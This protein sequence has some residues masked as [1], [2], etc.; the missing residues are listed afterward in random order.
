MLDLLNR[1]A[2]GF[3]TIPVILACKERGFFNLL[4]ERGPLTAAQMVDVLGANSGHFQAALRLMQSL[5]WLVYDTETGGYGLTAKA[6]LHTQIPEDMLDLY[7]L[8][9]EDYLMGASDQRLLSP[10]LERSRRRWDLGHP[11]LADFLDGVLVVPLLLSLKKNNLLGDGSQIPLFSGVTPLAGEELI[12][13]FVDGGWAERQEGHPVLTDMGRFVVDRSLILGTTASYRPMLMRMPDLLFGDCRAVFDRDEAGNEGHLDRSLNVLAS[14]FQHGKYFAD[15]DAII[16]SIFNQPLADQPHYIVDM[17]CGDGTFLA[18]VYHTIRT[19]SDRGRMLD[20]HPLR[21]I[22]VDYNQQA[23]GATAKTLAD[24]PHLVLPGDIGDP[25]QLMLNLQAHG[26]NFEDVLHI[27]SFLDHNRPFSP[28]QDNEAAEHR[29]GTP[30]AGVFVDTTGHAIPPQVMVQSLVEHLE[31]WSRAVSRHGIIILEVHCLNP[32]AVAKNRDVSES[33]HFDAY[34]AFSGQH[35]VEADL[36]LMSAAEVGLFPQAEF[37]RHY[38]KTLP[39]TRITLTYFEKKPYRM[40]L[41]QAA[42]LPHLLH[43]E[44]VCRPEAQRLSVTALQERLDRDPNGQCVL[45]VEGTIVGVIYSRRRFAND[46]GSPPNSQVSV[47]QLLNMNLLPTVPDDYGEQL[48][49]FMQLYCSVQSNIERVMGVD[50]CETYLHARN[51]AAVSI[52]RPIQHYVQEFVAGYPLSAGEDPLHPET[53]LETFGM[54]WLLTLLQDRG[55]M[56]RAGEIYARNDLKIR[57]RIVPQYYRLFDALLAMFERRGLLLLRDT[58]VETR[59]G[60]EAFTLADVTA[61]AQTFRQSFVS[62]YP[63]SVAFLNLME[64]CLTHYDRVLT[65]ETAAND[66]I[67]PEGSMDLFAGIFTG[68]PISDYFNQLLAEVVFQAIQQQKA[69]FNW[70]KIRILEIGAGTGGA[71]EFVLQKIAALSDSL[72]FTYSDISATFTRYGQSR[73]AERFPWVSY[74]TLNIEAKLEEQGFEAG[75]FDIVY[76]SNVLHDTRYIRYTLAQ[77]KRLLRP[78]GIVALNEFTRMKDLLLFTGGLLQGWWLF[79]DPE[80]RLNNTCLLSVELWE[81]VLEQSGFSNFGVFLLPFQPDPQNG[82]QSVMLCELP[83]SGQQGN[84][85]SQALSTK[86]GTAQEKETLPQQ[87]GQRHESAEKDSRASVSPQPDPQPVTPSEETLAATIRAATMAVLGEKRMASYAPTRPLMEMGLD[88]LELMELRILLGRRLDADIEPTFFFRYSTPEAMVRYFGEQLSP[89]EPVTPEPEAVPSLTPEPTPETSRTTKADSDDAI[90][91]I[92]LACRFPGGVTNPQE[93]WTLLQS[94]ADAITDIPASRWYLSRQQGLS[95]EPAPIFPPYGGFVAEIDRFDA[96]FFHISPREAEVMDPKQRILLE[97]SWHALEQAGIDPAALRESQTGVFVGILGHDY[98]L[99]QIKQHQPVEVYFGSGNSNSVA[100]GRIAYALGLQGPAMAVNTACSSSLV[101]VH[102]AVQSLRNDECDLALA[103]GVNLILSPELSQTFA[104]SGMLAAD[105]RC[106]TFDASANGYVRSEGCGVVVLK[107]LSAAVADHDNILAVIRGSAVNQDGASNGLTAPN[108]LAQEALLRKA[109]QTAMIEPHEVSYVEAH[110][111]GTVLG[112]PIEVKALGKVYGAGRTADNPLMVG[113]LKTNIGHTEAAAGIAGLIK[114][115]LSLQHGQIPPHLHFEKPNPYIPWDAFPLVI[116]TDVTPWSAPASGR[117]L[118]GV[119]SF[120]FSG[121]NAHLVIEDYQG[122]SGAGRNEQGVGAGPQLI[123]LSAKTEDRLRDYAQK[124]LAFLEASADV[125]L[126]EMAYTLQVGRKAMDARLALVVTTQAQL[127]D[128]L[129][130]YLENKSDL[131]G[132]HQGYLKAKNQQLDILTEGEEAKVFVKTLIRRG[133]LTKLAQLWVAGL[134]IEWKLLYGYG[135]PRRVSLPTYPFAKERYWLPDNEELRMKNEEFTSALLHQLVHRNT[136]T[137][138]EQHYS[139]TFKGNEFFLRDHQVRGEK[140]LPGVAYLEMARVAGAL[141]VDNKLITQIKD[142]VWLKPLVVKDEPL[143]VQVGLY[144]DERDEIVF[145]VSSEQQERVFHSQGTLAVREPDNRTPLDIAA[146]QFRCRSTIEGEACYRWF[147]IQGLVYGSTFRGLERLSYNEQEALARLRLPAGVE[148]AGYGLHPSLLDAALQAVVGLSLSHSGVESINLSVPFAVQAVTIYGP[149]PAEAYAYVTYSTSV[150]LGAAGVTYDIA[151]TDEQGVICV[152]LNGLTLRALTKP[153][154]NRLLYSTPVWQLKPLADD[155]AAPS[156]TPAPGTLLLIGWEPDLVEKLATT[157]HQGKVITLEP[158]DITALVQASW[159]QLKAIIDQKPQTAAPI[160]IVAPDTVDP[161]IYA[162][163]V[164]LLKTVQLEQPHIRGKVI[165]VAHSERDRLLALLSQ[166]LQPDS[167]RE[168]EIRYDETGTRAV[169]I[170][171]ELELTAPEK[172]LTLRAG[173]A[174]WI[175]GGLGELGRIFARHL[176]EQGKNITVILSGR[177]ALD[178]TGQKFLADLNR[179]DGTAVYLPTD[180]S[181]KA[182]VERVVQTITEQYGPLKGIIHSAGVIKDSF[183]LNKTEAEIEAVLA[184]KVTGLLNIDEATRNEKLDFV[185]LFSSIA[186]VWGNIGQVDYAAANAFLDGFAHHRQ[187]LVEAGQRS[188]RTLAIDWPLWIEGGMTV[189]DQSWTLMARQTGLSPL[190]TATGLRAFETLMAS[191]ES[192]VLVAVGAVDTLR[193]RL[194][195]E[196]L[197]LVDASPSLKDK[198]GDTNWL[199]GTVQ[200]DLVKAVSRILKISAEDIGGD[201]NLSEYGFDSIT[202]TELANQLN[203]TYDLDLLPT[204]F[205]EYNTLTSLARYLA[206]HHTSTLVQ[207]YQAQAETRPAPAF[208]APSS[209]PLVKARFRSAVNTHRS[210]GDQAAHLEAVAIIGMSGVLPGSPDLDTFWQHLVTGQDLITET[211]PERWDWR[212]RYG[213]PSSDLSKTQ[214]K[215]SGFI[216]DVDKF[217]AAFFKISPREAML[218]DPQQRLWLQTVWHCIEDA[219]YAAGTLAGTRTGIFVGVVTNDYQTLLRTHLDDLQAHTATGLS[220]SVLANR[221]SYLLDL[222]GPS[223]P[224]DTACSSSLVAIHRAVEALHSGGCE[225]AIAGGVN[226]LLTPDWHIAFGLAGMLAEDGR[227]KTFDQRANGYV[228]AEGVGAIFLKPLAQAE[229]DGDH[230]YAVIRATAENH[231]GRATSLTAPNPN[232]QADLLVSAYQQANLDPATVGYIEAHGTGTAL[233]DPIEVNGLKQAFARLYQQ[234]DK[235]SVAQSHC[236]LGSVKSNIGHLEAA[237]GIAGVLKVLLAMKHQTL[238]ASINFEVQNPYIDLADSPFYVVNKTQA[239]PP[240]LGE[241]G[242]PLPR[243]AGVSSFGFGGAN[244]HVVLEEYQRLPEVGT[245]EQRVDEGPQVIVLSAKNEERLR[246]YAQRLLIYLKANSSVSLTE[247]A[248]TLQAGREAMDSRLALVVSTVEELVA[249]LSQ[250]QQGQ[251]T[252]EGVYSGTAQ[253]NNLN[254]ALL[255]GG[256]AGKAFIKVAMDERD[257]DRLAQLWVSGVEFDWTLLYPSQTPRRISLPTYPFAKKRYW[258]DGRSTEK[259]QPQRGTGATVSSSQSANLTQVSLPETSHNRQVVL[260][261]LDDNSLPDQQRVI[262]ASLEPLRLIEPIQE[263]DESADE[264]AARSDKA[265]GVVKADP[266]IHPEPAVLEQQLRQ[267]LVDILYIEPGEIDGQ[268]KFVDFGL[269]S[270]TGVE[271]VKRINRDFGLNLNATRLY[272]YPTL[273][274]LAKYVAEMVTQDSARRDWSNVPASRLLP[275]PTLT[276]EQEVKDVTNIQESVLIGPDP[277]TELTLREERSRSNQPALTEVAE[278]DKRSS[279]DGIAIIGVAGRFPGARNVDEFWGNLAAGI[280]SIAEVPSDRWQVECYY[281]PDRQA[282]DKS[283]SKWLGALADIDKFDPLFFNISPR[284][285]ELMDPQQRLFLEEAWNALEDAGYAG[286][287]L[288]ERK[289]GV[290]VGAGVGDYHSWL[291]PHHAEADA[292]TL[293]GSSPSILAARLAYILNLKGAS[294]AID[295]ACSSSL[296]AIHEGCQSLLS[297]QNEMVLAGGVCVLAGPQ[298]HIMTSKAQ[299]LAGDGRCKTFDQRADGF[300]IAEGVGVVVLKRLAE[301]VRDGDHIYGVIKG[302]GLNQDG[303]TNGITAPSV[304]SQTS[305]EL[306]VYRGARIDPATISLV[307]AHGTGTKLGDPIEVEAL[308]TSFRAYT[309]QTGFCAIGSVKTNIG[310]TLTAAGVAGVIKVLLAL[311]HKQLPP[312]LHFEQP[313]EH[314]DFANSPFYV[315]TKL[316]AWEVETGPRRAAV[317]SFG[318][319]GTNAHLVLEEYQELGIREQAGRENGPHLIVLS[320]RNEA[321][322]TDYV[323]QTLAFLEEKSDI[324]LAQ[325]AYTLQVGR[326]AMDSRLALV[327][328][329][330]E[331]LIERLSQYVQR[332]PAVAGVYQGQVKGGSLPSELLLG[333]KAGAAFIRVAIADRELDR[334]AQLWV[335]GVEIEW[336][337]LYEEEKPHRM[338]LPTY[339]FAR[340]RYWL[341]ARRQFGAAP[342]QESSAA[343]DNRPDPVGVS[344]YQVIWQLAE[345][346]A[347]GIGEPATSTILLFYHEAEFGQTAE[348]LLDNG[349]LIRVKLGHRWVEEGPD[350][351][352][353]NAEQGQDYIT[354]L[355]RLVSQTVRPTHLVYHGLGDE[356]EGHHNG[357]ILY[358]CVKALKAIPLPDI[359]LILLY[360]RPE[361]V[362]AARLEA[363]GGYARSLAIVGLKFR[364]VGVEGEPP[365]FTAQLLALAAE[366]KEADD[367][368]FHEVLYRN[369]ERYLKAVAPLELPREAPSPLKPEGVYWITGG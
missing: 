168:V 97:E 36:F 351:Y 155:D 283:Y 51:R 34:H 17:G 329:G 77:V 350:A 60:I 7:Q 29:A 181:L 127:R 324:S 199:V 156:T 234:W 177:S 160:L 241:A 288:A 264:I 57:L 143:V 341:S 356:R 347:P 251:V 281:D 252:I 346:A 161:Y 190:S 166:E 337:L 222:H 145:K 6:E 44:T 147:D 322:L 105:G 122:P 312:T 290:F 363:L 67:F 37:V 244:A 263:V 249:R 4:R 65:G 321:R 86:V 231:G 129:I 76:A 163:L 328:T 55:V 212:V 254:S 139:S 9:M 224:I 364:K 83:Q 282:P 185:V 286:H 226:V 299:M 110:G 20:E 134:E 291:N 118:A 191:T 298:M 130:H 287:A 70:N 327:V 293:L 116:P 193:G 221:I 227:C 157:F 192:Q 213:D 220:H 334:L 82:G 201:E 148:L 64:R 114:V 172:K 104:R 268:E 242:R 115:V 275:N 280:D 202:L 48:L 289:C 14:G 319:S 26:I 200:T 301:A 173:G 295:T 330:I 39:F 236:G 316:K 21:M 335:A 136:S 318:F 259:K 132:V 171:R 54:R 101:A 113:S 223:E 359:K 146:I 267:Q 284:E 246:A 119:S 194:L 66:V 265:S 343:T 154:E 348:Q 338:S 142:V 272:D 176:L 215:W 107:R 162:P 245:G 74:E 184:P 28:P 333:G 238:P 19:R 93:F 315:N 211:P 30:Y 189:D 88:S 94:G 235:G 56:R 354:L 149:L 218:M 117:R 27:R 233:G 32:E 345:P 204:L 102:L 112:D 170:L 87:R 304:T 108:G 326:V 278:A 285:A 342:Y 100:A 11:W 368:A 133:E 256:N 58:T 247:L 355:E 95:N 8:S 137:L 210:S 38:P 196:H 261:A 85:V 63:H 361:R 144:P 24:I 182:D 153:D 307:E 339:P 230:I 165:T 313:N 18:Q 41:A 208:V 277:D 325:M 250:Y 195:V 46:M 344:T 59:P 81:T 91:I 257:F 271:W 47:V 209:K 53:M 84:T 178:E 69:H 303:A 167:F 75:T 180:V 216:D 73:F 25:E 260:A 71:T 13:L 365:S 123:V 269:D 121:T 175:T 205:F 258:F 96:P 89:S 297:G 52:S 61:E 103:A 255:I 124:L 302:S 300:G 306:E 225:L 273:Q 159:R 352:E 164:G 150:E 92:G 369:N 106:K 109:L 367:G 317:S 43:L 141:A 22:G 158:D 310:H 357:Q 219:G 308:T 45:E 229:A 253:T 152:S 214:V 232:A 10:W 131:P 320:A 237:A 128:K 239:W 90:A 311:K 270:I 138:T 80:Y 323:K 126:T 68:D 140:M 362:E 294:L 98:E 15:V 151:L 72:E 23:L 35:L 31:R 179:T 366:L 349:R 217:D 78:G 120:G 314:I 331:A 296:V 33:L 358:Q 262:P 49:Q 5:G 240:L 183:I 111:T 169:K 2:H 243:R 309:E 266:P 135:K 336:G 360:G 292:Y 228:R 62:R 3:V 40:R 42:D 203:K 12:E 340:E 353:I 50:V 276:H 274:R 197:S 198:D 1:Y 188:G 248:Y 125:S 174:Y 305:L 99:L 186:G 79:E 279:D 332:Q 206:E 207:H 187:S 16:V